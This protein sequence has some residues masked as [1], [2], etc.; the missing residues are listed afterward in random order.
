MGCR[1][2]SCHQLQRDLKTENVLGSFAVIETAF[3]AVKRRKMNLGHMAQLPVVGFLA[4]QA[5]AVDAALL[6]CAHTDGLAVL[7]IADGVGLGVFQH[8]QTHDQ[9]ALLGIGHRD[10]GQ[11]AL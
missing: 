2:N 11:P 7:H 9:I 5:G 1:F 8:D 10:F 3:I 6:A 4:C